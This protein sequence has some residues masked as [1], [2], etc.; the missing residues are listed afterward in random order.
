M[1]AVSGTWVECGYS[2]FPQFDLTFEHLQRPKL[3]KT[4]TWAR[5]A[6]E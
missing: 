6:V 5:E 3:P 4:Q 2:G 1:L